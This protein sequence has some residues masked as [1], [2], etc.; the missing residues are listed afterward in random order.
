M[1]Y[2]NAFWDPIAQVMVYGDGG[3]SDGTT[4]SQMSGAQDVVSHELSHAVTSCNSNLDYIKESGALNEAF[5]DIMGTTAEF[6]EEEPNSSNC[7]REPAQ[8]SCADWW[9]GEDLVVGGTRPRLQEPGQATGCLGSLRTSASASTRTRTWAT[10]C[11][12]T[13]TAASTTNSGIA[14]QAFYLLA[15]GG[16]NSRCSGPSDPQADCDVS[17][18]GV[19]VD[20]AANIFFRAWMGLTSTATFCDAR[21]A[22]VA[23][24]QYLV[25][26]TAGY[27]EDD[28]NATDAAW[29]AVGLSC[30]G[31]FGFRL[32]PAS[33][34]AV[35]RPG[36]TTDVAIQVI[37]GTSSSAVTFG[38]SDPQPATASFSPNPDSHSTSLHFDV[39][40]NATAGRLSADR[41]RHGRDDHGKGLVD[42]RRRRRRADG[43]RDRRGGGRR[44]HGG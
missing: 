1:K 39:P 22:S 10:A 19:G 13:T 27:T 12:P 14:N 21:N 44:W 30:G 7:V 40:G 11:R 34:T 15:N 4:F 35:A 38:I 28:L 18:H 29:R 17:T 3:S 2:V 20:H 26:H 9:L 24:A 32:N 43:P 36:G 37:S 25:A 41:F 8:A 33:D 23:A 6:E 31:T 5:S 16:R 42:A